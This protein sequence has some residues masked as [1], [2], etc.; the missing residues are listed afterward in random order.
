MARDLRIGGCLFQRWNQQLCRAHRKGSFVSA[1]SRAAEGRTNKKGGKRPPFCAIRA[2][3]VRSDH[4]LQP[5]QSGYTHTHRSWLRWD[6]NLGAGRRIAADAFGCRGSLY[7][8]NF[9]QTGQRELADT[10]FLDVTTNEAFEFFEHRRDL[11]TCPAGVVRKL[12]QDAALR[13]LACDQAG[14]ALNGGRCG[15]SGLFLSGP[16]FY[17]LFFSRSLTFFL[18]RRLSPG[19]RLLL[20]RRFAFLHCHSDFPLLIEYQGAVFRTSFARFTSPVH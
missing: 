17:A 15:S 2:W 16:S 18:R 5:L 4:A 13:E 9:E 19:W 12:V 11:F 6:H 20:F 3:R 7:S 8:T 1:Q 10:T 14:I